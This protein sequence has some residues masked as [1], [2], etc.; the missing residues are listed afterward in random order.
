[1]VRGL[2]TTE[3]ATARASVPVSG[4]VSVRAMFCW[5]LVRAGTLGPAWAG[6]DRK[7]N[8]PDQGRDSSHP[9]HARMPDRNPSV[10]FF[11]QQAT[12][13]R[14]R[15]QSPER[16]SSSRAIPANKR[17]TQVIEKVNNRIALAVVGSRS[18][19]TDK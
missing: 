8:P 1:M 5:D 17:V 14:A 19:C 7:G 16:T 3:G 15:S 18:N 9:T 10:G 2:G 4:R 6:L 11:A 13:E 12:S